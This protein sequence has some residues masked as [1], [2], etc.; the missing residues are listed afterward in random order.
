M[1]RFHILTETLKLYSVKGLNFSSK[2][3]QPIN[4]FL[5]S[6]NLV[7]KNYYN[8]FAVRFSMGKPI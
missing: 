7:F 1:N 2:K 4:I 8:I 5:I 6:Y 3:L